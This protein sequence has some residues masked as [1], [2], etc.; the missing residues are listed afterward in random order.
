VEDDITIEIPEFIGTQDIIQIYEEVRIINKL[1]RYTSKEYF[2]G[3]YS[4]KILKYVE[5]IHVF[6]KL[7]YDPSFLYENIGDAYLYI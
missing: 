7:N 5:A 2:V 1:F 4:N 3:Y 6:K